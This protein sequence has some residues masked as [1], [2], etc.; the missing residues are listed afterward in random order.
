MYYQKG[1]QK[2]KFEG[3]S[4]VYEIPKTGVLFTEFKP[5]WRG[6]TYHDGKTSQRFYLVDENGTRKEITGWDKSD[7]RQQ[8][9]ENPKMD[10]YASDTVAAF[11]IAAGEMGTNDNSFTFESYFIGP[12]D[13]IGNTKNRGPAYIDSL[14]KQQVKNGL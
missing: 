1:G 11:F 3:E 8:A 2:E 12:H 5:D 10:K 7:F 4:R 6:M 14:R 13:E 9:I